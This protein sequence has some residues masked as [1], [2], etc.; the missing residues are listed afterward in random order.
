MV[1][2]VGVMQDVPSLFLGG[3][4]NLLADFERELGKTLDGDFLAG[5]QR[6]EDFF[7]GSPDFLHEVQAA[8]VQEPPAQ[9]E[10]S[11]VR[12]EII[13]ICLLEVVVVIVLQAYP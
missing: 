7:H 6:A 1:V 2:R 13:A 5:I 9:T 12:F 11:P 10:I 8:L 4:L 3:T